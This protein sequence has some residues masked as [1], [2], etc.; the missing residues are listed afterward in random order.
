MLAALD[1]SR[2]G[3]QSLVK[4]EKCEANKE[5]LEALLKASESKPSGV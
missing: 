2:D 1:L 5:K 4:K 3:A